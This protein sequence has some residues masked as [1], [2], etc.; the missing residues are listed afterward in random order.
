MQVCVGVNM[1][2]ITYNYW[3]F[4]PSKIFR[5]VIALVKQYK[6]RI[7]NISSNFGLFVTLK[8]IPHRTRHRIIPLLPFQ[9]LQH[10]RLHPDDEEVGLER[11][12][13]NKVQRSRPAVQIP[14]NAKRGV[15]YLSCIEII[16][17]TEIKTPVFGGGETS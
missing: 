10:R 9:I 8:S 4:L 3:C 16:S 6:C 5:T 2:V 13:R 11:S 12:E 17:R 1:Y 15:R 14:R 7:N